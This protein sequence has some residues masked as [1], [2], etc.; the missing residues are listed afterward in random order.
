MEIAVAL[1]G[2]KRRDLAFYPGD[3]LVLNI[4]VYAKD[5]DSEPISVI[6]TQFVHGYSIGQDLGAEFTVQDSGR[7]P[8]KVTGDINGQTTTL[9]F[10]W[11]IAGQGYPEVFCWA[12]QG[13]MCCGRWPDVWGMAAENVQVKDVGQYYSS[14]DAEG[15]LQEVGFRQRQFQEDLDS[16]QFEGSDQIGFLQL[17]VTTKSRTVQ[18]KLRDVA[19][20]R[21]WGAKGNGSDD[22]T[23]VIQKAI[24]ECGNKILEFTDGDFVITEQLL[25]RSGL[26]IRMYSGAKFTPRSWSSVGGFIGNVDLNNPENRIQSDIVIEG[27][28]M[29]CRFIPYGTV[30]NDNAVGFARG[31][32]NILVKNLKVLGMQTSYTKPGG[33]GGKAVNFEAGVYDSEIDG[34]TAVDCGFGAFIQGY[35]GVW[36]DNGAGKGTSRIRLSKLRAVRC[37]TA[38]AIGG[39]NP[40]ADPDGNPND[41]F[42]LAEDILFWNCGHAP[43]RPVTSGFRKNGAIVFFEAQ[44]VTLRNVKGYN[45]AAYTAVWPTDGQHVGSGLTGPIGA[46]IWGWG[47]NITVDGFDYNGDC[48]SLISIQR[49]RAI[50]DDAPPDATVRNVYRFDVQNFRHFGVTNS[51]ISVDPTSG[52]RVPSDQLVSNLKNIVVDTLSTGIVDATMSSIYPGVYAEIINGKTGSSIEGNSSSIFNKMNNFSLSSIGKNI[53]QISSID[54]KSA[55]FY[56][57]TFSIADDSA[58]SID[59]PFLN[60]QVD[61]SHS[62]SNGHAIFGL[63]TGPAAVQCSQI[64]AAT[65]NNFI[66]QTSGGALSGTTGTDGRMTISATAGAPASSLGLLWIENRLG[67]TL[68]VTVTFRGAT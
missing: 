24:N 64:A 14:Q 60:G 15:I 3:D 54:S 63:R 28:N 10:G 22:D 1:D 68:S 47:R 48:D 20:I 31:A 61:V 67:A 41:S 6:N 29:D 9:A 66:V 43:Q 51:V 42:I 11:M 56:S 57:R 5:G 26:H 8:Y 65:A 53:L 16:L 33:S 18:N 39:L 30:G 44:N 62:S 40:S 17:G 4:K 23:S 27:V 7:E 35:A 59:L 2:S 13:W 52:V 55:H 32:S 37:D 34:V 49:G 45:D 12:G 38:L 19:N 46:P 50:G 36:P 21:D 25:T 58:I